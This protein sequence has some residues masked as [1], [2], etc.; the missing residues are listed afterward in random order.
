M[1][2]LNVIHEYRKKITELQV[3]LNAS[4]ARWELRQADLD[5]ILD[6]VFGYFADFEKENMAYENK[7]YKMKRFFI[8]NCRSLIRLGKYN[9]HVIDKPYGYQGDFMIIEEIY[10]NSPKTLGI[11]RCMDNY[12]LKSAASI[13]TRNRKENFKHYL[14]S[15][16]HDS[17]RRNIRILDLASGPCTDIIEFYDSMNGLE[18]RVVMDCFEHDINA[19]QYSQ[20]K[21]KEKK[22]SNQI[23]FIQ[24]NA[25]KIALTKNVEF[26]LPQK[27][28]LIFSTGLFDY[29]DEKISTLLIRNLKRLLNPQGVLMISNYRDKWSNPSRHFMEWG[30][31]WELVYR[32]QEDF[33][34]MFRDAG[35]DKHQLSLSYEPL[36]IMQYCFARNS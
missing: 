35:F 28:D 18:E 14:S 3:D 22:F 7:I 9:R 21:L 29:L 13:A 11:E 16:I 26:Y 17:P 24:K 30:G 8:S 6:S 34:R 15:F 12:F 27:Y 4:P 33:V 5:R 23:N 10:R 19:I 2:I 20:E 32:T 31:D 1:G 36:K 25:I